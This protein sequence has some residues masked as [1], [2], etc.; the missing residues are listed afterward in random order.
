MRDKYTYEQIR[1]ATQMM[2]N[3]EHHYTNAQIINETGISEFRIRTW[4]KRWRMMEFMVALRP[5]N[6]ALYKSISSHTYGVSEEVRQ[7]WIN[8]IDENWERLRGLV[9]PNDILPILQ[10]I[11]ETVNARHPESQG[12]DNNNIDSALACIIDH[13]RG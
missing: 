13:T 11:A 7:D 1:R 2:L 12:I 3:E 5:D 6:D 10:E 9:N 4:R 8:A